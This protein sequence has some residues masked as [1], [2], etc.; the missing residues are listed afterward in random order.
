MDKIRIPASITLE[1]G[2]S[3]QRYAWKSENRVTDYKRPCKRATIRFTCRTFAN[4]ISNTKKE[5][6]QISMR[7]EDDFK[8]VVHRIVKKGISLQGY[9]GKHPY[10]QIVANGCLPRVL[11]KKLD[12]SS[13]NSITFPVILELSLNDW[14]DLH[15]SPSDFLLIVEKESKILMEEALNRGFQVEKVSKGR[16]YD[17]GLI[18]PSKKELI[19]AISSH[20]AKSKSRSK[21]KTI[22]KILMDISKML[23]YLDGNKKS[24]PIVITRPIE[25]QKSWSHTTQKYLDFYKKKFGFKFITT[26]FKNGWE[27]D[28]IK[29]LLKF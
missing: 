27:D 2:F 17:L 18:S 16:E 15:L 3:T 8:V 20:V 4:K 25:F 6:R 28:I 9:S 5:N 10:I 11:W 24:I 22:Q 19:I 29:E 7:F 23:P 1:R 12:N 13:N 26:E 21:E 14:K